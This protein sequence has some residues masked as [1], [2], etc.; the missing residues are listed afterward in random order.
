MDSWLFGRRSN[1]RVDGANLF[2]AMLTFSLH[3]NDVSGEFL[4][5]ANPWERLGLGLRI[6]LIHIGYNGRD[7]VNHSSQQVDEI[8]RRVKKMAKKI[9]LSLKR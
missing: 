6:G 9:R 3:S 1:T 8:S 5:T 2:F 7:A 4:L